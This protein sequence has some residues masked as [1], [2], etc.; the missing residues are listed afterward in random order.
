VSRL[1]SLAR[2]YGFDALILVAALENAVAAAVAGRSAHSPHT[3]R[4][5][6]IPASAA[7]VL[8]LLARRRFPFAAPV[9]VWLMGAAISFVDGRLAVF[10]GATLAAGLAAALLLGNLADS[11]EA[12]LGLLIAIAG[13]AIVVNNDPQHQAEEF[14][15][16]P[17]LVSIAWLAGFALR[18]R[19]EQTEAAEGR[20]R[21]A[22]RE[23]EA[24]ARVAVAEERARIARELHDIV[25]HSLSVMVLQVGAVRH[26][27]AGDLGEDKD[28]LEDVERAGRQALAEMRRLLGAMRRD[29]DERDLSPQPSLA[30][31]DALV[32]QVRG[33][34]LP[35]HMHVEG[36]PLALPTGIELSVYR[37]I[38]EGLTNALKHARATRADVTLRY[39]RDAIEVEVR[40]DGQGRA[41]TDG[42]GYGLLGIQERVK[43]YGGAMTAETAPGKGFALRTRLPL[44]SD[45][46]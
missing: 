10:N 28:A 3:T 6:T 9:S 44:E 12:R 20:A 1:W 45:R 19:S 42:A 29:D 36:E 22:E 23:R 14:I 11:V 39:G 18:E 38:Q 17:V 30:S 41:S 37:I 43:I 25:A 40:D 34:G 46:R 32:E 4:W 35:V 27:L 15:F 16:I 2:R 24:M 33:A 21:Q 13:A 7:I 26:R 31:V 5:F 8:V